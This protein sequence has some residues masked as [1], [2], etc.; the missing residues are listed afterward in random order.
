[1]EQEQ[2]EIVQEQQKFAAFNADD[3]HKTSC[4]DCNTDDSIFEISE[5]EMDASGLIRIEFE[6]S[7]EPIYVNY[8]YLLMLEDE[9]R[10]RLQVVG[11]G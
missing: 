3:F 8:R 7:I 1:M 5:I 4:A 2:A 10:R 9:A 11:N 6:K